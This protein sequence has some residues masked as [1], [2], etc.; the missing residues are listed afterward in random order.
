M[1]EDEAK[2]LSWFGVGD[3]NMVATGRVSWW[4]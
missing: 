4:L 1:K 2:R 3:V